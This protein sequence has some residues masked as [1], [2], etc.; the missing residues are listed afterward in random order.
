VGIDDAKDDLGRYFQNIDRGLHAVLREEQAPLVV[1]AVDYLLP[2]YKEAST[3]PHLL[4]KGIEGNP[5]RLSE[6]ELH[7]RAW[8]IVAPHFQA[9]LRQALGLYHQLAGTGRATSEVKQIIPATYRG[10]VA[11]VFLTQGNHLWGILDPHTKEV[12]LHEQRKPGDEDL[13]NYAAI[14]ALRHGNTVYTLRPEDIPAGKRLA[15]IYHL[16][17][18]K[19]GKRA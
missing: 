7:D 2:I 1:A 14:Q 17:R 5:D 10:E 18:S 15:A 4:E 13:L 3:Y 12:Y 6:K 8:A 19:H 16:P 9:T 11:T